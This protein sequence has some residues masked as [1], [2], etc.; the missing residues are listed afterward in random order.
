M[1]RKKKDY[2]EIKNYQVVNGGIWIPKEECLRLSEIFRKFHDDYSA[3][4]PFGGMANVEGF[5]RLY[6]LYDD[7]AKIIEKETILHDQFKEQKEK[8]HELSDQIRE[9][10]ARVQELCSNFN[11]KEQK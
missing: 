11:K 10:C 5:R 8:I 2:G 7:F 9:Q 4:S 6:L 1:P 3:E